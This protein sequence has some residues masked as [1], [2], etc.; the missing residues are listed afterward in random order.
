MNFGLRKASAKQK[1]AKFQE[2]RKELLAGLGKDSGCR[3]GQG[4]MRTL[5]IITLPYDR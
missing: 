2:L 3:L 5:S 4:C 1:R